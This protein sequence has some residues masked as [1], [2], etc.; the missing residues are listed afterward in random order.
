MLMVQSKFKAQMVSKHAK[1]DVLR[2]YWDKLLMELQKKA[3]N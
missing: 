3:S 1:L 2:N